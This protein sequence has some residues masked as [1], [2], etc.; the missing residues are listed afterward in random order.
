MHDDQSPQVPHLEGPR[1]PFSPFDGACYCFSY[2]LCSHHAGIHELLQLGQRSERKGGQYCA[3]RIS[4]CIDNLCVQEIWAA[5]VWT[6]LNRFGYHNIQEEL[7]GSATHSLG[8]ILTLDTF[9]HTMFDDLDLCL[10]AV[11][12]QVCSS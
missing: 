11:P 6:M 3:V 7:K 10:E 12:G 9:C 5:G 8:N 1:T 4:I 2:K